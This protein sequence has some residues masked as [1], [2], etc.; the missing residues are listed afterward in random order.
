[1]MKVFL[2]DEQRETLDDIKL[3]DFLNDLGMNSL[4]GWA[5]AV[6]EEVVPTDKLTNFILSDNDRII[7][8]Q[9]TQGG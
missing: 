5:V 1:M 4:N 3:I 6:N 2:N 7:L 9:A 8:I